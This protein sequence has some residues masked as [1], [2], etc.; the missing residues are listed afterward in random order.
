MLYVSDVLMIE[1]EDLRRLPLDERRRRLAELLPDA[2]NGLHLSE[3]I[4]RE[5]PTVFEHACRL[6][7]EGIISKRRDRAYRSGPCPHWRKIKNASY[8]RPA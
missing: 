3:E 6:G 4:H 5:G 8:K 7:L 2:A 1:G